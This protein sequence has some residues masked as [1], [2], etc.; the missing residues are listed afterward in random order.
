[1]LSFFYCFDILHIAFYFIIFYC[2][3]VRAIR[4]VFDNINRMADNKYNQLR[5]KIVKEI[6]KMSETNKEMAENGLYYDTQD[7]NG[8]TFDVIGKELGLKETEIKKFKKKVEEM[9]DI[10]EMGVMKILVQKFIKGK[11]EI[12]G[13]PQKVK[14]EI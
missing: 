14:Y 8:L 2:L 1:M 9:Q 7:P 3:S 6:Q 4:K 13:T 12:V 5:K 11:T 10:D